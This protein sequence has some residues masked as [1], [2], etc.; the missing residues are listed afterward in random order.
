METATTSFAASQSHQVH[1]QIKARW[2]LSIGAHGTVGLPL[3]QQRSWC[4]EEA[5]SNCL[6]YIEIE[7][8]D[9]LNDK[10][11]IRT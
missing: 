9:A 6:A 11:A 1:T 10:V 5:G 8:R 2:V 7:N 4:G 3:R